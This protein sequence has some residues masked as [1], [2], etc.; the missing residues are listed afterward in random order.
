MLYEGEAIDL[1]EYRIDTRQHH[2]LFQGLRREQPIER[3]FMGHI[4]QTRALRMCNCDRQRGEPGP[5]Q[6]ISN[7]GN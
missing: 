4:E 6:H 7:A 5:G 1:A 3:V 2:S